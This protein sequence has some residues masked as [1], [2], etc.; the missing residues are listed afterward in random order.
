MSQH[1]HDSLEER[2]EPDARLSDTSSEQSPRETD[3][4][5]DPSPVQKE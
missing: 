2:G 5:L 3:D 4:E 1:Q